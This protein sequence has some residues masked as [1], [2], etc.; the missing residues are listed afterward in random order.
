ME[1]AEKNSDK[2]SLATRAVSIEWVLVPWIPIGAAVYVACTI[3]DI[4]LLFIPLFFIVV[5]T[6]IFGCSLFAFITHPKT[7][8]GADANGLYFYYRGGKEVFIPYGDIVKAATYMSRNSFGGIAVTT[9]TADDRILSLRISE[10]KGLL[11]DRINELIGRDE[12]QAYL[13]RIA[14]KPKVKIKPAND[15]KE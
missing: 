9:S 6:V 4:R 2:K 11:A 8:I 14:I 15:I 3:E 5:C 1:E 7:V 10:D 12:K 13:E